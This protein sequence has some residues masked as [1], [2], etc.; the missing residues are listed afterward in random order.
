MSDFKVTRYKLRASGMDVRGPEEPFSIVF[1]S[2]LHNKSYG[3]GNERLLQEI[4]SQDP[5]AV[6]IGGDLLTSADPPQMEAALDLMKELTRWYPIYAVNGNHEQRLKEQTEKYGDAYDHYSQAVRSFGVHLLENTSEYAEFCRMPFRI[7]GYEL[8]LDYYRRGRS[9]TLMAEQVTEVLGA[10]KE[11]CCNVLLAHNPVYFD[12]YAAWGAD[13]TLSGHLHGGIVRLPLLGGVISP[14]MTLFPDY[15]RG[16]Y[17]KENHRMI[18][19]A[20]LGSHTIP[21][22]INNPPELVVIDVMN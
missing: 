17:T 4:R 7:W 13:L 6:L 21:I 3:K 15:T 11:G 14:Q 18:V 16:C 9:F 5:E 22:R 2:D 10:P 8:P 20:G 1:L 12:T 19:G